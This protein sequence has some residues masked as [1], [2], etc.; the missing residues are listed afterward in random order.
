MSA[1]EQSWCERVASTIPRG[2]G[3]ELDTPESWDCCQQGPRLPCRTWRARTLALPRANRPF[4]ADSAMD[5]DSLRREAISE[6]GRAIGFERWC[7]LLI[8]PDTLIINR[9]IGENDWRREL[10]RLNFEDEDR[11]QQH[12]DARSQPRPRR[13]AELRDRRR[14]NALDALARRLRRLRC[15]R[16]ADRG[17]SQT[18][19]AAGAPFHLFRDSDDPRFNAPMTRSSC[20][21][22]PACSRALRRRAVGRTEGTKSP[23]AGTGVLVFGDDLKPRQWTDAAQ[24]WFIAL[25]PPGSRFP[26]ASQGRS[27]VPQ[28]KYC[29]T[30]KP[31]LTPTTG[32]VPAPRLSTT[33][34]A[35]HPRWGI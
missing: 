20:A 28:R 21:T 27:G 23:P 17:S 33:R 29:A 32:C 14:A 13:C 4:L 5:L 35:E 18:S 26:T 24:A 16:R 15:R 2:W 12:G 9:G 34:H 19:S 25:N 22:S 8:D 30:S 10:S 3:L 31:G 6:L 7:S 11:R 1:L